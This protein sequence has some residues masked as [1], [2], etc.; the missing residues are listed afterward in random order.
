MAWHVGIDEAGYGPNLGPFVMTLAALRCPHPAEAD[1]WQLL[2]GCVRRA[3]ERADGRLIVADSKRI[4]TSAQGLGSL[5]A[6]VL[7][8]LSL[9]CPS[10]PVQPLSLADLWSRYCLTSRTDWQCEPWSEPDLELP[11]ALS[12]QEGA[13]RITLR[14]QQALAAAGVEEILFRCVVLFPQE[15][16]R[17]LA[18]HGT[19]AAATQSA[20]LRLLTKLPKS[21]ESTAV[22]RL[23]VDKHGGRHY[24]Y[25]L[26]QEALHPAPVLIREEGPR[27]SRYWAEANGSTWD[28]VFEPEADGNHFAVALASMV[29]KYLRE[30]LMLQFNR[31]WLKQTPGLRPTAGYPVDARRFM[32]QIEG[33]RER[34]GIP[35]ELI[36]R[37]K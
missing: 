15:F 18:Q 36:W 17:L 37:S 10:L 5:E 8:F 1:L 16:N 32:Q 20:F 9:D 4:H 22:S 3:E 7:P 27:G 2:Q 19:K 23:A 34:L 29:S 11:A 35:R 25:E 26:L 28:I 12:G 24:Y 33:P 21:D 14:L 6:N 31:F 30:L 13:A